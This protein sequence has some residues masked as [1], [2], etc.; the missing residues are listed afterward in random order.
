MERYSLAYCY[1]LDRKFTFFHQATSAKVRMWHMLLGGKWSG[2]YLVADMQDA[3]ATVRVFQIQEL[4]QPTDIVFPFAE[5]DIS[6]HV[7][8]V[9]PGRS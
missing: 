1:R 7:Q 9:P 4:V 3:K 6:K 5:G 8:L 2:D